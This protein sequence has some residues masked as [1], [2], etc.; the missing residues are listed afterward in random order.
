[1]NSLGK[2][3]NTKNEIIEI[4]K[5][6]PELLYTL[7]TDKLKHLEEIYA[8]EIARVDKEIMKRKK[9]QK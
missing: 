1:M 3:K 2:E 9:K 6:N 5:K 7:T 4:I 8:E